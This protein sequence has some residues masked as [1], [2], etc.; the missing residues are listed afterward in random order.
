MTLFNNIQGVATGGNARSETGESD[1]NKGKKMI[2]DHKHRESD[3]YE[4][5]GGN[6]QG[7]DTSLHKKRQSR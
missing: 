7:K 5:V 4:I 2:A 3:R 1:P 6:K